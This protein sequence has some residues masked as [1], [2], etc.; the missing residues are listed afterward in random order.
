MNILDNAAGA[1]H[2]VRTPGETDAQL[3]TRI[4]AYYAMRAIEAYLPLLIMLNKLNLISAK[5]MLRKP[6]P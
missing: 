2:L 6:L 1:V 5:F 3:L 4:K